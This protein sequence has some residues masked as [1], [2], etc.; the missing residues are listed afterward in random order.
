M[1]LHKSK[2][3][4]YP[5]PRTFS[6]DLEH[7]R[8]FG[9]STCLSMLAIL[10]LPC[11]KPE[12]PRFFPYKKKKRPPASIQISASSASEEGT[13]RCGNKRSHPVSQ[14]LIFQVP[15]GTSGRSTSYN[16]EVFLCQV[17]TKVVPTQLKQICELDWAP[18][19]NKTWGGEHEVCV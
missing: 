13:T 19:F 15:L 6:D 11:F 9:F 8:W 1:L 4:M 12:M 7:L 5:Y 17:S 3:R 14:K 2:Q 16:I 10:N 18:C